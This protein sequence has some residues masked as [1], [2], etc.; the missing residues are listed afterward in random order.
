MQLIKRANKSTYMD[1][2]KTY[3]IKI[4]TDTLIHEEN[5]SERNPLYEHFC[6]AQL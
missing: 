4:K 3:L 1:H 6:N 5:T 2:L